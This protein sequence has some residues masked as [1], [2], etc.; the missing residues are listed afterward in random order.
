MQGD[1]VLT[2]VELASIRF[3]VING[4]ES[5]RRYIWLHGDEQTARMAIEAHMKSHPGLAFII[6]GSEREIQFEGGM[7]D[8]NRMFSR[9]GARKNLHKFNPHWSEKKMNSTLEKLDRDRENFLTAI[10]PPDSGLIIALHNNLRGYSVDD[11]IDNS[12]EVSIKSDQNHHNF[13]LCTDRDDFTKLSRSP[14]NVVLQASADG[15]DDGSLSRAMARRGVRY[16]NIE[17]RLGW[18]SQQKKMLN[19]LES[20]LD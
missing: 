16:I 9:E 10:T 20:I 15:E 3:E 14:F 1:R 12:N 11:E 17:V 5:S 7:L 18:L 4:G 13:F 8:P 2:S 19:Y 6:T